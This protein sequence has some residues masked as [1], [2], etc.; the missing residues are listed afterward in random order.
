[1]RRTIQRQF[2]DPV[3]FVVAGVVLAITLASATWHAGA[4]WKEE[5]QRL[6]R[7]LASLALPRFPLHPTVLNQISSLSGAHLTLVGH[8][9]VLDSTLPLDDDDK[10][11]LIAWNDANHQ[12]HSDAIDLS[13][14][15]YLADRVALRSSVVDDPAEARHLIVMTPRP[16]WWLIWRE[17]AVGP[18]II[19][20]V[21][22]LPLLAI[23]ALR[24]RQVVRPLAQL[25]AQAA[26]IV[27]GEF[28]IVEL[29]AQD[30]EVRDLAAAINRMVERL[31]R[32][33]QQVR[34]QERLQTLAQLAGGM[35]HHLRNAA[36]GGR[37]ALELHQRE[38]HHAEGD[39]D[40]RVA[41]QQFAQIEQ[42]LQRLLM[43][44][45]TE[46]SADEPREEVD[47]SGLFRQ[48]VDF[49]TPLCRHARVALVAT[50]DGEPLV[51]MGSR[52]S[53]EQ[54]VVNL[55]INGLEAVKSLPAEQRR[56]ALELSRA[57]D[58][59]QLVVRD[60][61]PGPNEKIAAAIFEPFES[62]KPDGIG[63]GLSVARQVALQHGGE[64]SW[65]RDAETTAFTVRLPCISEVVHGA[66]LGR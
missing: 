27:G 66:H 37:L 24:S 8:D 38:C 63:L 19:G 42:Y 30:D 59:V 43:M 11:R 52:Q 39:D 12:G 3:L 46:P 40:L 31:T 28:R 56:L 45:R 23:I 15:A 26:S 21:G 53:L 57:K 49:L 65:R 13:S 20:V 62:D 55:A 29:P 22:I 60:W 16:D 10:Q 51:V 7:V 35:A 36:T 5:E 48:L 14:G 61:G 44:S 47:V 1:M 17:A 64:V 18:L 33:E 9:G 54:V 41:L 50:H 34:R 58:D 6:R 2:Q 32:F 25:Q 4:T